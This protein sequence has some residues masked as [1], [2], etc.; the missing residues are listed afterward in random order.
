MSDDAL[1]K[2]LADAI[3]RQTKLL[4]R[5]EAKESQTDPLHTKVPANWQTATPLHG[6]GGIFSTPGLERDVITAYV[7]PMGI[8]SL[9]PLLPSTSEDPRFGA[10]T[11][12]T[13]VTG[14]EP[15]NACLDAPSGYVKACNLTAR[16]GMLRRDTKTIEMDKVMLKINRGDFTDLVLRGRVLGMAN[17]EPSGLDEGRILDII[18]MS[19]MVNVGVQTERE[20][21]RQMWQ[22]IFA[23]GTEFPG[24]DSQ[25]ATGQLDVDTNVLCPALDSD[26]KNYNFALLSNTIVQ[27]ASMLHWYLNYNA[28][29][30]G[31]DPVDWV[32]VMRPELWYELT[33]IWPCAY[34]T[35]RCAAF[36]EA[37]GTT[38]IDG[39][40]NIVDRDAMRNGMYLITNGVK[41]PVVVDTG[42]FEHNST[43][44]AIPAG[45]YASSMY[46]IPLTISGNFP[47]TY[48][49]Y[50]DYRQAQP[51]ISLLRGLEEF[52]W[53]DNGLFTWAMEQ[54]K[55]CYKLSLKTEQRV[56]LRTPQLAGR[57]DDVRYRPL[58]HLRDPDPASVY[59][60][61]GGV[62]IRPGFGHPNA[63]WHNR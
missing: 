15:A 46:L 3:D 2:M 29:H 18:T 37:G 22:G 36:M 5:Y 54:V 11:G 33:A 53:T 24:L 34:N 8:G 38:V 59:H 41:I 55:W 4:E 49:E 51:D 48:R 28:T 19:E 40:E 56:V 39:R 30:M 17:L 9:L 57:I 52:F 13:A 23:L 47:V 32:W 60:Y 63:V 61:D 58:Q 44:T 25:I 42:I 50:I 20:L 43:N 21:N 62:S 12:Y 26:V 27:Y 16:F 45:D 6:R 31:L 35:S 7:R 10:L 1:L 14:A